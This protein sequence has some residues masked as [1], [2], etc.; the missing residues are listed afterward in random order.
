MGIARRPDIGTVHT[1]ALRLK[2][3]GLPVA[4]TAIRRWVREGDLPHRHVG[5][6]VLLHYPT[7]VRFVQGDIDPN[8]TEG[9]DAL[10]SRAK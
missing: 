6:K 8:A 10:L 7:V 9:P 5:S 3:D 1:T 4:E 2:E